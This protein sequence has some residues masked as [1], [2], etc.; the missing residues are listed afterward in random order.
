[1]PV[2]VPAQYVPWI[3]QAAQQ[4]GVPAPLLAAQEQV[5]SG[6]NPSAV[7]PAGAIGIAQFMPGTAASLGVNPWDPRS[8]IFGQ[9]RYLRQLHD[10][11]GNW[12]QA[13]EA[14]NT[15]P[16]GNLP[17]AAGYAAEIQNLAQGLAAQFSGGQLTV[18]GS[19]PSG[20]PGSCTPQGWV[21]QPC[22]PLDPGCAVANWWGAF[23]C[24][25]GQQLHRLSAGMEIVLG[26]ALITG[27]VL[28]V[29]GLLVP[30]TE[31]GRAG[32]RLGRLALEVAR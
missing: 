27:G 16:A 8:S 23:S 13:L 24:S 30:Q 2:R 3:E 26:L 19:G 1:V 17:A 4:T 21:D 28:V 25:V 9:A 15:G 11:F 6:F 32:A 5:E 18:A 7:S 20:Q 10:Q 14:Y 22:G 29:A 12:T 31:I